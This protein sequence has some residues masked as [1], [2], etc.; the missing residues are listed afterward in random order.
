MADFNALHALI[1]AYIKKNGVKAI[2]GQILNGVLSGMVNALGKGFTVAGAAT[3]ETDPG[4]MTGPLAY[5]AYTAGTYPHFGGLVVEQGEVAM[6]MFNENEWTKD[7]LFS[8]AATASV[9]DTVGTPSVGVS[10]VD[11]LLTFD[12][13]NLKGET[14]EPAGFGHVTATVDANIGTPSVTVQE[15]GPDTAKNYTFAFRNLKGETG[16]TSVVATVDNTIG[17]PSCAVSLNG[18]ELHLDF[19]G[20]KGMQGDTG[21]SADYPIAIVNNLTTSDPASALS[22]QMGVQLEAEV[23]QLEA[24]VDEKTTFE[25]WETLEKESIISSSYISSSD[26]SIST[27]SGF[28]IYVYNLRNVHGIRITIENS[29]GA[30][31]SRQ[32]GFYNDD[33]TFDS[34]TC[35]GTGPVISAGMS[36]TDIVPIPNGAKKL[37]VIRYG[38][39]IQQV[40]ERGSSST[41]KERIIE[42]DG[43]TL[44]INDEVLSPEETISELYISNED[45]TTSNFHDYSAKRYDVAELE[46]VIISSTNTSSKATRL[47]GFYSSNESFSSATA[48]Q[49]GPLAD[50]VFTNKMFRLLI[51]EGSLSL[52]VIE[53]TGTLSQYAYIE[54]KTTIKDKASELGEAISTVNEK[55]EEYATIEEEQVMSPDESISGLYISNSSGDTA[56]YSGYVSYRFNVSTLSKVKIATKNNSSEGTASRRYAFYN[57]SSVFNSSTALLVGELITANF[58]ST[59]EITVP[60]GAVSLIAV[61]V[62]GRITQVVSKKVNVP[63]STIVA[64]QQTEID[65][66]KTKVGKYAYS[67]NSGKLIVAYNT[68]TGI[69]YIFVFEKCLA[70]DLFTFN[71]CGYRSVTRT[72]PVAGVDGLVVLSSA[73]S[74]SIGPIAT[75][76]GGWQGGN[77]LKDD[78]KTARTDSYSI[79]IDGRPIVS[80]STGTCDSIVISVQ[81]TFFDAASTPIDGVL[82][83]VLCWEYETYSIEKNNIEVGVSLKFNNSSRNIAAYYGMQ[84]VFSNETHL[85]TPNGE[86]SSWYD[87]SSGAFNFSKEDFPHFNRFIEKN[88]NGALSVYLIPI[89]LGKHEDIGDSDFIFKRETAK[90]YHNLIA[91]PNLSPSGNKC[92]QWK[93][94]YTYM[95]GIEVD[96]NNVVAYFGTI[97]GKDALF[98]ATTGAYTGFIPVPSGKKVSVVECY[99]VTDENGGTDFIL[100]GNGVYIEAVGVSSLILKIE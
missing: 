2:T 86:K 76:G 57:S 10:F 15:S 83:D 7:V 78:M 92:C 85:L 63:V 14:G 65:G 35:L 97:E 5:I 96:A 23:S 54:I 34:T 98:I 51:P 99:G 43:R 20:L 48:L 24:K 19:H 47:Y 59:D 38:T 42:L 89:S 100:A 95:S 31:A 12:F 74:D 36:Q 21:V 80:N 8:L 16:V 27:Y 33:T 22:A 93:G 90:D 70:N 49:I 6:F 44:Y 55:V 18:Q 28:S 45:G 52:L 72:Y 68:G 56:S 77:H 94:T 46:E 75:Y 73:Y 82:V 29:G 62:T 61:T 26:G 25:N 41:V 50:T 71:Q 81:N 4:T 11:G 67:L 60:D 17:T 9:D 91:S 1:N 84:S 69:E 3:P 40:V 58:D 64:E 53:Y 66:L 39:Q 32:Y 87:V 30:T 13:H 79:L 37:L 88:G